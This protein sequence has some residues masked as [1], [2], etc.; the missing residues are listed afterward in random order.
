MSQI[1]L[2]NAHVIDLCFQRVVQVFCFVLQIIVSRLNPPNLFLCLSTFFIN[3]SDREKVYSTNILLLF[4]T[5]T[6]A[7]LSDPI[8]KVFFVW[9]FTKFIKPKKGATKILFTPTEVNI[10]KTIFLCK[11]LH[12]VLHCKYKKLLS[13]QRFAFG[14]ISVV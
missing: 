8:T 2:F 1:F 14:F 12:W 3:F 9:L 4:S 13:M 7:W 6:S 5:F 10:D 11:S